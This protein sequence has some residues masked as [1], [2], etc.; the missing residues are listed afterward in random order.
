MKNTAKNNLIFFNFSPKKLI[1]IYK[2]IFFKFE[3][4]YILITLKKIFSLKSSELKIS[5]WFKSSDEENCRK[6]PKLLHCQKAHSFQTVKYINPEFLYHKLKTGI[7]IMSKFPRLYHLY[8]PRS[9]LSNSVTIGPGQ[10][11]VLND[12]ASPKMV[13]KLYFLKGIIAIWI[14]S[15][16]PI[17][18]C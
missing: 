11:I 18:D 5:I 7:K 4:G 8:F 6:L 17:Y 1:F 3:I 16:L 9:K 14:L 10:F 15:R 12:S 2:K 13:I